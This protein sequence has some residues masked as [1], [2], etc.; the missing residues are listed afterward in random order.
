VAL[1]KRINDELYG[2]KDPIW[3]LLVLKLLFGVL[4]L[5]MRINT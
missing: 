5:W 2:C 3:Q 1:F 4:K